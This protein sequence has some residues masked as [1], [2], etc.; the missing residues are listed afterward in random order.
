VNA[1]N[2]AGR[3]LAGAKEL[4]PRSRVPCGTFS[5]AI[6]VLLGLVKFVQT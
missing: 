5:M 6:N 4:R 3:K 2:V 1:K